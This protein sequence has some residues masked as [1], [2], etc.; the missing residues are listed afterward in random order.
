MKLSI[1]LLVA[2][3][4]TAA[5]SPLPGLRVEPAP[6][7]SVLYVRNVYSQALT[8][9]TVELVDYPGSRFLHSTDEVGGPGIS[10]GVEKAIPVS[11]ML[12]GAVSPEYVKV[13]AAL[14]ADGSA[15]GNPEDIKKILVRR[16]SRLETARELIHR[17]DAAQSNGTAAPGIVDGLKH[18]S[19]SLEAV[20]QGTA[21]AVIAQAIGDL[22]QKSIQDTL[23]SL[24]HTEQAIAASK[25]S[26]P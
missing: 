10:P 5:D 20:E 6:R 22:E 9:F 12:V 17:I 7:G 4:L 8:A 15:C 24:K 14:Y 13:Q 23:S 25:P 18:W 11:S 16:K 2:L 1:A 26:L 3:P 21:R 19:A